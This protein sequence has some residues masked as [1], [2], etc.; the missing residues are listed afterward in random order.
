MPFRMQ[1]Y[2]IMARSWRTEGGRCLRGIKQIPMV[3]AVWC[4]WETRS[5]GWGW[6]LTFTEVS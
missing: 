6:K 1:K 3:L 5:K 2:G 4:S